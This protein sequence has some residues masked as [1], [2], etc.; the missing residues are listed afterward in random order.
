MK[1]K[2]CSLSGLLMLKAKSSEKFSK[3]KNV[4][5]FDL[6]GALEIRGH[7]ML[8]FVLQKHILA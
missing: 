3:S 1:N 2:G 6:L 5:K 4:R 8:R 7:E